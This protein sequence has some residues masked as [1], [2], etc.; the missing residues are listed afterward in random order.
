MIAH[1]CAMR[2]TDGSRARGSHQAELAQLTAQRLG[3]GGGAF[4][5]FI[6]IA[7]SVL[8]S[9]ITPALE[10]AM[11][12]R[13]DQYRFGVE[14]DPAASDPVFVAERAYRANTLPAH[15]LATDHPIERTAIGQ[16]LGALGHHAR[17]V[18]VLGLFAVLAFLLQLF[19]DPVL[20]IADRVGADA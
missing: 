4:N 3:H 14:H 10:R 19:L 5:H 6:E 12:P 15:H 8:G 13:L 1:G 18:D 9:E 7:R 16:L 17:A 2:P 11:G 20:E